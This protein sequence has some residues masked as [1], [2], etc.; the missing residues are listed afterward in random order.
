MPATIGSKL[1]LEMK[2][3][4]IALAS[5]ILFVLCASLLYAQDSPVAPRVTN[6]VEYTGLT[7]DDDTLNY[8]I[9]LVSIGE[10]VEEQVNDRNEA[11]SKFLLSLY[12]H[13]ESVPNNSVNETSLQAWSQFLTF[14]FLTGRILDFRKIGRDKISSNEII[15]RTGYGKKHLLLIPPFGFSS[16]VFEDFK[17]QYQDEFTFHEVSFPSGLN[18]LRYPDREGYFEAKWLSEVESVVLSYLKEANIPEITAVTLG[19]GTYTAIKLT[20]NTSSIKA[21]VCI[22]GQYKSDLVDPGTG[23]DASLAYRKAVSERAFPVSLVIQFS[24]GVLAR[25][26]GL[27]MDPVK[28]QKYLNQ[29]TPENANAILRYGQEFKAQDIT[30]LLKNLKIPILS[31]ISI[32]N[33]QSVQVADKS[34]I[35]SWEE[36]RIIA[37]DLPLYL[38]TVPESQNLIFL[39]RPHLFN[40]YFRQFMDDPLRPVEIHP[41]E[42]IATVELPSPMASVTQNIESTRISV[43]YSQP[44]LNGRIA[45]GE[46][47]PYDKVWRAGANS[48][49]VLETSRDILINN[50]HFLKA[51]RYSLF[52][53][54]GKSEWQAI[55]NKIPDQWG[56]FNYKRD[57][58]ALR[59]NLEPKHLNNKR[60]FLFYE[61]K[62]TKLDEVSLMMSWENTMISFDI[63]SYFELPA[64]PEKLVTAS[65][66]QLLTDKEG[67]GVNQSLTDGKALS[68]FQSGD[69][70]WFKFDLHKY[71]NKKAF[72]LNVLIDADNNQTTGSPWFGTNTNFTFDKALTLWMQKSGNGFQ[73]LNGI[74]LPDDFTSGNQNLDYRNNLTYYLDMERKMY[75]A[76]VPISDLQL[77]GRKIR[78]IG[79]V[80]EFQTWN[81]DIGDEESAVITLKKTGT[82]SN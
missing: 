45:F 58:D 30:P 73:G 57:F 63:A 77:Q 62:R 35:R 66:K 19:T 43:E 38:V 23:S 59:F 56:A 9:D 61:L 68:Y 70:L 50:R 76:G 55:I 10:S 25:N 29:I 44:A 64:P 42:P 69:S 32:H 2:V 54:P 34:A 46:L 33:D 37:P 40:S 48:A 74:M 5:I 4:P 15:L 67:D 51:G 81:D 8:W 52:F 79:A 22:N 26:Y 7:L 14:P 6:L 72:A 71:E 82:N 39:D 36:L 1:I 12:R 47:V 16:D 11:W 75:I 53:A 17:K 20:E 21:I 78:L 31:M 27:S 41:T 3:R 28:N 65:W 13:L 18:T 49:T 24:P 80:G 60:E